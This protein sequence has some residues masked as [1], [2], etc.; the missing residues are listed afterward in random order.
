MFRNL[1]AE[2]ARDGITGKQI[3]EALGIDAATISA[4][5]NSADR[6]KL[7]EAMKIRSVFFADK[8]LDYL[9]ATDNTNNQA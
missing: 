4:K 5:L 7:S 6:M 1:R 9:F 2:M 8:S 3:A